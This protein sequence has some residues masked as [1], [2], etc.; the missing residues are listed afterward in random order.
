LIK[1][2]LSVLFEIPDLKMEQF[3]LAREFNKFVVKKEEETSDNFHI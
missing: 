3:Q 2:S 1:T